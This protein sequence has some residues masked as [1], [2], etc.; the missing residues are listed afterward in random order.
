MDTKH[1]EKLLSDRRVVEEIHRHQWF[2]SEKAG[3]DIGFESAAEDWFN[4][5]AKTWIQ[6]HMPKK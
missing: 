2:E 4:K 5:F 3:H 1:K 6:Y